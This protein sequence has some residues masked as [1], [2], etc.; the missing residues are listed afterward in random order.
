MK[1]AGLLT[2]E[3]RLPCNITL[4]PTILTDR[5]GLATTRQA[6]ARSMQGRCHLDFLALAAT[7]CPVG[8][9][10]VDQA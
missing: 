4:R 9:A 2:K 5:S 7:T 10:L 6:L 8:L 1:V 3:T